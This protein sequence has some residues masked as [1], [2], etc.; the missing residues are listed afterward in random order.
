M[1][2]VDLQPSTQASLQAL[3]AELHVSPEFV[4]RQVIE[5]ALED[6]EDYLAG[7][8]SLAATKYT[9]SQDEMERRSELAD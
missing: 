4:A 5:A 2:Q 1:I 7:I 3:A 9:I 6:R 8:R